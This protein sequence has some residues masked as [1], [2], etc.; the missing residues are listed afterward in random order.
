MEETCFKFQIFYLSK[1]FIMVTTLVATSTTD[2]IHITLNQTLNYDLSRLRPSEA[3]PNPRSYFS[4]NHPS[5]II[6]SYKF[7]NERFVTFIAELNTCSNLRRLYQEKAQLA[8]TCQS[9]SN[10]QNLHIYSIDSP[11]L[12]EIV[13][14]ELK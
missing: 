4:T 2:T 3:K 11:R 7:L 13:N 12:V 8:V 6:Q 5:G 9:K 14:F 1:F 10:Q